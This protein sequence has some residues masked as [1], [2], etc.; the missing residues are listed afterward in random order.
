[1]QTLSL[2][3]LASGWQRQS[4]LRTADCWAFAAV[5]LLNR[6]IGIAIAVAAAIVRLTSGPLTLRR[7]AEA[8]QETGLRSTAPTAG[9]NDR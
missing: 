4:R 3:L 2:W 7:C 5:A 8:E 1:M 9:P 6:Q